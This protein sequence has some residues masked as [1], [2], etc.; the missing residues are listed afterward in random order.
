MRINPKKTKT[1]CFIVVS[2]FP[3]DALY[4]KTSPIIERSV[5]EI[6]KY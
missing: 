4:K 5:I 1:D 6:N 3:C 2:I